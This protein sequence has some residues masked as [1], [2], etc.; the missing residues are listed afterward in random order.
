MLV[1]KYSQERSSCLLMLFQQLRVLTGQINDLA[2][3]CVYVCVLPG[4]IPEDASESIKLCFLG[5][6]IWSKA[7]F[8]SC[9]RCLKRAVLKEEENWSQTSSA[10]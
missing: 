3:V 10:N 7:Q 2:C 6:D 8:H 4:T 5:G 1:I 9:E